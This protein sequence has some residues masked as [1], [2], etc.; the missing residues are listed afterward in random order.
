MEQVRKQSEQLTQI[1]QREKE[2]KEQLQQRAIQ[3]LLVVRPALSGDLTV[4]APITDDEVG[5]IADA[6]NN[7]LQSL[8]RTVT[9]LQSA[10]S[11]VV[12]TCQGSE[13]NFSA[14]ATQAQEQLQSLNR[15]LEQIQLMVN[16]T[17]VVATDAQ[18]VEL[19]A[20]R[21]NQTVRQGDAAMNRTVDGILAIRETVTETSK[22]INPLLS[23]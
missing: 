22:L 3:L 6:Y 4:R 12:Q 18:Q 7:T 5:T 15:A 21:A 1:A 17:A 2:T 9:Q 14:L 10:G 23:L 11:I 13:S 20:Q 16:S 19:A 8:R